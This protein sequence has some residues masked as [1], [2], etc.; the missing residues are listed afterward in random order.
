[1]WTLIMQ[2]RWEHRLNYS[3]AGKRA[4]E[5][6]YAVVAPMMIGPEHPLYAVN[7][8]FNGILVEGN[9]VDK[10]MISTDAEPESLRAARCRSG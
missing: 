7:D 9:M 6:F 5:K 8:V 4:G 3:E 1:M 10:L 2:E